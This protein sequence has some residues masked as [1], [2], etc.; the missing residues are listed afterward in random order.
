MQKD[1]H[2]IP[3]KLDLEVSC[4]AKIEKQRVDH[5]VVGSCTMCCIDMQHDDREE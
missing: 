5:E 2:R 1:K 3:K 4:R